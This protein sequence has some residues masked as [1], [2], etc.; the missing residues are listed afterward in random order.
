MTASGVTLD[1][2]GESALDLDEVAVDW[3]MYAVRVRSRRGEAIFK[4]NTRNR[5]IARDNSEEEDDGGVLHPAGALIS[6][7]LDSGATRG[8]Y[9]WGDC[10]LRCRMNGVPMQLVRVK[11]YQ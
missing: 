5:H 3:A 4:F 10:F 8:P 7:S 9:S 6:T 1:R 2:V 11:K